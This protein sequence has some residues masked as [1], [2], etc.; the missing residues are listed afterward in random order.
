MQGRIPDRRLVSGSV[1]DTNSIRNDWMLIVTVWG[2]IPSYTILKVVSINQLLRVMSH[3]TKPFCIATVKAAES[4][5]K[6]RTA[7]KASVTRRLTH[8]DGLSI[9]QLLIFLGVPQRHLDHTT[10]TILIDWRLPEHEQEAWQTNQD[11]VQGRAEAYQRSSDGF[12]TIPLA[13][14]QASEGRHDLNAVIYTSSHTGAD[15][16]ALVNAGTTFDHSSNIDPFSTFLAEVEEAAFGPWHPFP[17]M[18]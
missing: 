11:F 2:A 1:R 14:G 17:G 9:G 18:S 6:A 13:T 8:S 4:T 12:Q 3:S 16:S 5:G 7:M 15:H 10:Q